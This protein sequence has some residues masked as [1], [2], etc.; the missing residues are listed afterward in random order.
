[1]KRVGLFRKPYRC[2]AWLIGLG[3]LL[4]GVTFSS[5]P[6][7]AAV[8][9]GSHPAFWGARLSPDGKR[10]S[11][12][13]MHES[14]LPVAEVFDIEK[15]QRNLLL[16]SAKDTFDISECFWANNERLLC[17]FYSVYRDGALMYP[18]T[19]LVGVN[20]D[21]SRMKVLLQQPLSRKGVRYQFQDQIV[22]LLAEEPK[23]VLIAMPDREGL[24]VARLDIYKGTT[25]TV[26]RPHSTVRDW[27]ADGEGEIRLRQKLNKR[28]IEWQA[29]ASGSGKWK[30]LH[31]ERLVDLSQ[32]YLPLGFGEGADELIVSKYHEGKNALWVEDLAGEAPDRLVFS[33]PDVDL[34]NVARV[35]KK[36]RLAGVGYITDRLHYHFFDEKIRGIHDRVVPLFS[37]EQ[38]EVFDESWDGRFYL[39]KVSSDVSPGK[40]YRFDS[41]RNELALFADQ[42]PKLKG[43]SLAS[44]KSLEYPARDGTTIPAYLTTPPGATDGPRPTV[45]LPHGG[46]HSR[47][48]WGF[49]W[50]VQYLA[51]RGYLVF[52]MNFRGSGGFGE[53]WLGE[54][55]FR[56]WRTTL[57]DITDGAR[58]LVETGQADPERMCIAGWSYGGYAALLSGIEE[59]DLYRCVVSIA[60]VSDLEKLIDE[61]KKFLT[62]KRTQE[63]IGRNREV[64]KAGSPA[65]RAKEM[66]APTLLFHGDEDINVRLTQ[67]E[68]MHKALK[69]AGKEVTFI[70]YEEVEHS[71]RRNTIRIDMLSRMGVFLDAH[72]QPRSELE[73]ATASVAS[74]AGAGL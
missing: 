53:D 64:L 58:Y 59:S 37:G 6:D 26:E 40:I 35:G 12:L 34:A 68:K 7:P 25:R 60:G 71:L 28:E 41:K 20:A 55:G 63:Y 18:V 43:S 29:R 9:F 23:H 49:N 57:N 3:F 61:K 17:S 21:G 45:I 44:M 54:G 67:S 8:A 19:R 38:V 66:G 11:Y 56:D 10:I 62:G 47:D 33:H 51:A 15:G 74:S 24:G 52:Q 14:D 50:L 48:V 39:V 32:S 36:Q 30:T 13:R 70:E 2:W 1:M 42:Y 31:E 65:Q 16:A 46:P 69:K 72:T 73:G 27:M 4:P 22:D 5:E